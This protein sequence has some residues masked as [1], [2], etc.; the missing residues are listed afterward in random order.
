VERKAFV[1]NKGE[2]VSES[3]PASAMR[4]AV[5]KKA[6][7]KESKA[8]NHLA[9]QQNRRQQVGVHIG[10]EDQERQFGGGNSA[11]Q[12]GDGQG[13]SSDAGDHDV[14]SDTKEGWGKGRGGI[15]YLKPQGELSG[16]KKPVVKLP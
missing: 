3:P 1:K 4:N 10:G 12:P 13:K 15:F 11:A 14:L 16:G 2:E 6:R 8:R 5:W 9:A 7:W